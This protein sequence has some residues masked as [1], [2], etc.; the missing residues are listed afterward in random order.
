MIDWEKFKADFSLIAAEMDM[1]ATFP[2]HEDYRIIRFSIIDN[3][4]L[5]GPGYH[6]HIKHI[7]NFIGHNLFEINL[8]PW[9]ST[10]RRRGELAGV[11]SNGHDAFAVCYV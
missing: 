3:D 11:V 5:D 8:A 4:W 2:L 10:G 1:V 7:G 9:S 6:G